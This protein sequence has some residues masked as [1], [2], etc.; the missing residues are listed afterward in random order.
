MVRIF[1]GLG[2]R[3]LP[4]RGKKVPR[5]LSVVHL[6]GRVCVN[7]FTIKAFEYGTL[8]ILLHRE[9][10]VVVHPHSTLVAPPW[11][12]EVKKYGKLG[13]LCHQRQ[14]NKGSR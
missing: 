12:V 8:M 14:H 11:N 7:D 5:F 2:L 10:F 6:N 13:V 9:R 1:I 3:V 4:G